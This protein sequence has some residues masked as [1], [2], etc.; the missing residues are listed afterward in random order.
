MTSS[1]CAL[2][3]HS[4][5]AR[6]SP[7][8]RRVRAAAGGGRSPKRERGCL[9]RARQQGPRSAQH[10][11]QRR[12]L[13][14]GHLHHRAT[15]SSWRPRPTS[16]ISP[17]S[18]RRSSKRAATTASSSPADRA[19]AHEAASQRAGA[20]AGRCGAARAHD[21]AGVAARG[22]LRQGQVLPQRPAELQGSGGAQQVLA[23]S[24]D[25]EQL[26]DAWTGWHDL[27]A[28]CAPTSAVRGTGEQGSAQLGF[29]DRRHV[30]GQIRHAA[31]RLL[32]GAGPPL[33][34]GAAALPVAARLR[35]R[36][37]REKIRRC[38]C[39]P[40]VRF[41]RTCWATCGRRIGTTSTACWPPAMPIP[42]TI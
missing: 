30:A 20:G 33:G 10:R 25:P 14:A 31:R 26:L 21:A 1:L 34:T 32:P 12:R 41:P 17:T 9:R 29:K 38:W 22:H 6:S 42:A 3:P 13:D 28:A 40:A 36:R 7:A 27:A 23:E 5:Q 16:A 11:A 19:R 15:R 2:A 24:R 37:L 8:H 18:T 39:R 35:S 4:S